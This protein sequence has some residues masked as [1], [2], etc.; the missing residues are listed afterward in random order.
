MMV[1]NVYSSMASESLEDL[2]DDMSYQ[3]I[4]LSSV[5]IYTGDNE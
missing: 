5:E 2:R 1:E 4:E 3:E